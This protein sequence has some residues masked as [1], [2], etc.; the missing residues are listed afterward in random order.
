MIRIAVPVAGGKLCQHFGHC[1]SFA[2]I[3]GDEKGKRVLVKEE[4]AAPE[5][6]PG[7]L[8]RWL[9]E[10]GVQVVL[11]GGMGSRAISLFAE[12]GIKV[13]VGVNGT[14]P[15]GLAAKY[16]EGTLRSGDNIC[17]H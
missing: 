15:E 8:P 1:E 11:A 6:Q 16:L 7:L 10:K 4:V 3:D 17:D 12:R 13:L 5:H 14:S 9:A 2:L